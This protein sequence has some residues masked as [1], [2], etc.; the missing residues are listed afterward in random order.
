MHYSDLQGVPHLRDALAK[1]LAS[2]NGL[3]YSAGEIVVTNGLHM[4]S[5]AAFMALLEEGDDPPMTWRE[6]RSMTTAR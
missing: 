2:H 6:N 1:K 4:A 5:Y 3:D